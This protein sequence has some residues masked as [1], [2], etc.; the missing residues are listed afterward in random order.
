MESGRLW[1][2]EASVEAEVTGY[3]ARLVGENVPIL[4]RSSAVD[5]HIQSCVTWALSVMVKPFNGGADNKAANPK[6]SLPLPGGLIG[7]G[8]P[9][10]LECIRTPQLN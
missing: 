8:R 3:P 1:C 2:N 6:L 5:S 10:L 9:C 4:V 7:S